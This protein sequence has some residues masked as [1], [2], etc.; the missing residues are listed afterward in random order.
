MKLAKLP[1]LYR[2]LRIIRL[3]KILSLLNN[4]ASFKRLLDAI[5]LSAG[6]K[7][8][9]VIASVVFFMVHLMACVYFLVGTFED[10][11]ENN[12]IVYNNL[13]DAEPYYQY[14]VSVY[15]ALQTLTTV[16]YGDVHTRSVYEQLAAII[17]MIIG[18]GFF[19]F[20]IGNMASIFNQI[21]IKAAHLQQ[22][23]SIL[24]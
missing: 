24:N 1:R 17:W 8:L 9:L 5:N 4:N 19:S 7:R 10:E 20:T 3:F 23:L 13:L 14:L 6:I 12:W 2:L 18:V 22:K 21:D 15:W 11:D 16:G